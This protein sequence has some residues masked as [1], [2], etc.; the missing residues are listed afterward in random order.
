M[1]P[2]HAD[3]AIAAGSSAPPQPRQARHDHQVLCPHMLAIYRLINRV[4]V[5]HPDYLKTVL[6]KYNAF[7]SA[8]FRIIC[9]D[10][11]L[12]EI[13]GYTLARLNLRLI[14]VRLYDRPTRICP[15]D[16]RFI[17]R[18]KNDDCENSRNEAP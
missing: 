3:T 5:A 1:A 17:R 16:D 14:D 4:F 12:P 11:S 15:V 8:M 7:S 18:R 2:C 10:S 13:I 6:C 9:C